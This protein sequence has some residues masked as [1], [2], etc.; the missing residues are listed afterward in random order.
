[1]T[2]EASPLVYVVILNWNGHADTVECVRSCLTITYEPVRILVVDNGSSDGSERLLRSEFPEIEVIQTGA[3]LG[4]AGGNNVGIRHALD[5]GANYILLLNNDTLVDRDFVTPLVAIAAADCRVGMLCSKIFF[6]DAPDVIWFAGAHLRPLLG[7]NHHLGYG[8][9]DDGRYDNVVETDRPTGCAMMVSKQVCKAIGLL[10]EEMFCYA[11]DVD[12]G[13][14]ARNAGY[15][16][17]YVPTSKVWHKVTRSTGGV[18]SP[19]SQYYSLRNMLLCLDLNLPLVFPLRVFRYVTVI[20]P[21]MT[22]ALKLPGPRF[23]RL[24]AVIKG[25]SHYFLGRFGPLDGPAL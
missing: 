3:N 23:R 5:H 4:F 13:L 24:L 2:A 12:W 11:E 15:K 10:R 7:W 9:V 16:V 25:A 1:M 17:V 20:G 14:R 19:L 21:Y 22:S 6:H 8:Q 18:A